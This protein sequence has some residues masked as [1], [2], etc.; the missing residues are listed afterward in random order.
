[1]IK[2]DFKGKQTWGIVKKPSVY[3]SKNVKQIIELTDYV[4]SKDYLRL[5]EWMDSYYPGS[6][7]SIVQL[8]TPKSFTRPTTIKSTAK[9]STNIDNLPPLT[10][11]QV[12]AIKDISETNSPHIILHGE[13]GTGKTRVYQELV[14]SCI[15][16]GKSAIVLIPEISLTPQ[17]ANEFSNVFG[18]KVLLVHSSITNKKRSEIWWELANNGSPKILIG[19]RSSLFYPIKNLGLIILDE[20]HDQSYKQTQAPNYDARPVAAKLSIINKVQTIYGTATPDISDYYRFQKHKL[21]ILRMS[22]EISKDIKTSTKQIIDAKDRSNFSRSALFSNT[23]IKSIESALSKNN[24]SL[25]FLNRRGTARMVIC[26]SCG[27][28]A[29]CPNCDSNLVYHGDDHRL[30]CHVCGHSESPPTSCPNCH[31]ASLSFK[32]H[33][34]KSIVNELAKLFPDA[35]I[36]RFDSDNKSGES[37]ASNYQK[38]KSGEVDIIVGTQI[39]AKGLHVPR[40]TVVV[41][42]FAESGIFLPDFTSEEKAYQLLRQVVG[43]VGRTELDSKIILQSFSSDNVTLKRAVNCNWEEHFAAQINQRRKYHF[44]P[45]TYLLQLTIRR[46]TKTSAQN[47][48]KKLAEKLQ[49][50]LGKNMELLG[51]SPRFYEKTGG[52]YN[53]QLIV[54]SPNRSDL[55]AIISN[56]PADWRYN[57]DPVNLL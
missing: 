21:P 53:W 47:N 1:M 50:K 9:G 6:F 12:M 52:Y 31:N 15:N 40:L 25:I 20:S 44:P 56:L 39:I 4:F 10:A 41:V 43:R 17:I 36:M 16:Q 34:T 5:I 13:T 30:I 7:G 26:E 2:V 38:V 42:P 54:K 37:F 32:S 19:T 18:D 22:S 11:E 27:W 28:L 49:N 35:K 48:A 23:A 51:P 8:F 29:T 46:K 24:Q 14:R 33:G 45:F 3:K 55:T 57:I